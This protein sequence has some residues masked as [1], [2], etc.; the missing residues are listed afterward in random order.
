MNRDP[1]SHVCLGQLRGQ[2][3][4]ADGFAEPANHRGDLGIEDR[5][6]EAAIEMIEDLQV[7][8]RRMKDLEDAGIVEQGAQRRKVQVGGQGIDGDGVIGT[9]DLNQAE[10]P[11]RTSSR[12]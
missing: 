4:I 7:L 1:L 8:T 2:G 3:L 11:A 6:R 9:G 12:A 10:L 5:G